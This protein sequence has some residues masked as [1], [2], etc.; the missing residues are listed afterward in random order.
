M[1][2]SGILLPQLITELRTHLGIDSG[3]P[4]WQDSDCTLVLNR[5]LWELFTKFPFRETDFATTLKTVAGQREYSVQG[6]FQALNT[7]A[8][9]DSTS[10]KHIQLPPMSKFT[11]EQNYTDDTIIKTLQA[12]PTNYFRADGSIILYPTPDKVYTI[13]V[14]YVKNLADLASNNTSPPINFEWHEILLYGACWR[15]FIRIG[16]VPR[17][18]MYK[19]TYYGLI[20]STVPQPVKDSQ[21]RSLIGI[22]VPGRA[23][24]NY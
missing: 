19:G 12:I 6:D 1:P 13:V 15:G 14:H 11:Y 24:S 2:N 21:D 8:V 18:N 22:E 4:D 5:T 17:A 20:A 9:V 10:G 16:D 3:D 23:D 7:L